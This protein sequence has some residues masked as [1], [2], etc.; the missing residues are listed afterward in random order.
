METSLHRTLKERYAAGEDDRREVVVEG[1][2]S[3]PSMKPGVW[4]RS[5]RALWARCAAN[6]G[7]CCP[8]IASGSSSRSCSS[9]GSSGRRGAMDRSSRRG[10]ARSAARSSTSSTI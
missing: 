3:T 10:A 4:S 2:G 9:A 6:C 1:F 5:S 7:G 8:S